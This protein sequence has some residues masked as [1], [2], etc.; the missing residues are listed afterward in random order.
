MGAQNDTNQPFLIAFDNGLARSAERICQPWLH[1]D[2]IYTN[3][4]LYSQILKDKEFL[5][6]FVTKVIKM[7]NT[8]K[9]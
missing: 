3:L 6:N 1:S 8:S 5:W 9:V 4:P 2:L 7:F